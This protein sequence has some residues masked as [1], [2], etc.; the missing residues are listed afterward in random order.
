MYWTDFMFPMD[1]GMLPLKLLSLKKRPMFSMELG[2]DPSRLFAPRY[3][4]RK[5]V[6]LPSSNG[7]GPVK[8]ASLGLSNPEP[9][10]NGGE[11]EGDNEVFG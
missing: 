7:M 10:E 3:I 6:S 4:S 1:G 8:V 5:L 2:I 11:D 9:E